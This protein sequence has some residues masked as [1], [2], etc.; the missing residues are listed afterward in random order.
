MEK[1]SGEAS[2]EGTVEGAPPKIRRPAKEPLGESSKRG[3]KKKEAVA[4]FFC[5]DPFGARARLEETLSE[6]SG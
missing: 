5:G 6:R 2:E 3:N 4:S 1:L